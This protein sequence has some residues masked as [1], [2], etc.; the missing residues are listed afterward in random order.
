MKETELFLS[1]G[2][3]RES[4]INF[5]NRC[6]NLRERSAETF[7]LYKNNLLQVIGKNEKQIN[8]TNLYMAKSRNVDLLGNKAADFVRQMNL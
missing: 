8:E 3:L 6:S 5:Y 7:D 1:L 2:S 4:V